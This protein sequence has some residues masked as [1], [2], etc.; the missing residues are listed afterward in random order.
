[1]TCNRARFLCWKDLDLAPIRHRI[2]PN[3]AVICPE[4]VQDE[5]W[6]QC[7]ASISKLIPAEGVNTFSAQHDNGLSDSM[8]ANQL[9]LL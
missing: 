4:D 8:D 1:M 9:Y 2:C 3:Y 5:A 6:L 7:Q